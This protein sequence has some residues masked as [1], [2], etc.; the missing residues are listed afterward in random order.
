M[1]AQHRS[2]AA[3]EDDC[4]QSRLQPTAALIDTPRCTITQYYWPRLSAWREPSAEMW[5]RKVATLWVA[6]LVHIGPAVQRL[7][8]GEEEG[9]V[10]GE[11]GA[12]ELF[13][14]CHL[15][16]NNLTKKYTLG[17]SR[18]LNNQ[19]WNRFQTNQTPYFPPPLSQLPVFKRRTLGDT[20][21]Q[22]M[23]HCYAATRSTPLICFLS[24]VARLTHEST[25][26]KNTF[27]STF[28][29]FREK[30]QCLWSWQWRHYNHTDSVYEQQGTIVLSPSGKSP[31]SW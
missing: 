20:Q 6:Q 13:I 22:C 5:V 21:T 15:K 3:G 1:E 31:K 30:P 14:L 29:A 17:T 25:C 19:H 9:E 16:I 2:C 8:R 4:S 28:D 10:D 24:Q 23:Q 7:R 18:K 11:E 26:F 27:L 12:T